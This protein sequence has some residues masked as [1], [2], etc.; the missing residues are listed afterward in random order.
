[1]EPS[2]VSVEVTKSCTNKD[3]C[4]SIGG[5]GPCG[6]VARVIAWMRGCTGP[7]RGLVHGVCLLAN[8]VVL[9]DLVRQPPVPEVLLW[10]GALAALVHVHRQRE[11]DAELTAHLLRFLNSVAATSA[12]CNAVFSSSAAHPPTMYAASLTSVVEAPQQ[13]PNYFLADDIRRTGI[14]DSILTAVRKYR[15][16]LMEHVRSLHAAVATPSW[17]QQNVLTRDAKRKIRRVLGYASTSTATYAAATALR[18]RR[19]AA[20]GSLAP[21]QSQPPPATS[22]EERY[23]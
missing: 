5:A 10:Q 7:S 4:Q 14:H 20:A 18:E 23:G 1:M 16:P 6:L 12:T 21:L 17:G 19:S 9:S 2:G 13:R 11:A 3:H 22:L 15:H 8:L